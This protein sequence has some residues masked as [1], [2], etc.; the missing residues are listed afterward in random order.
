MARLLVGP[1]ITIPEAKKRFQKQNIQVELNLS[2]Q[3]KIK[4]FTKLCRASLCNIV[5]V[6]YEVNIK[7][8][9]LFIRKRFIMT[10]VK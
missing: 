6:C 3:Q 7:L 1:D 10:A 9:P 4:I 5:I 2:E 8:L